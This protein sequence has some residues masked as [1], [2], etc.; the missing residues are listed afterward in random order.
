MKESHESE[1]SLSVG[2]SVGRIPFELANHFKEPYGIDYTARF[3]QMATR[4]CE[5]GQIC[6]R[7]V[8]VDFKKLGFKKNSVTLYQFNPENPDPKKLQKF[9]FI[10]VDGYAL[11]DGT[12]MNVLSKTQ[13]L[14]ADEKCR[15]AVVSHKKNS[16]AKSKIVSFDRS[17]VEVKEEKMGDC[18]EK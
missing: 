9:D 1:R 2:C 5:N 14:L 13:M 8:E 6:Y 3:F 7:D 15:V 12:L 17:W 4:L 10:F 16:L 18:N 11:R